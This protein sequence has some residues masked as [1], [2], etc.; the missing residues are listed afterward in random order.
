[1]PPPPL[2][3]PDRSGSLNRTVVRLALPTILMNV[4][5]PLL[6]AVDTAVVGHLRDI[7][8]LGAVGLGSLLFTMVYWTVGFFRMSTVGLAAQAHGRGDAQESAEVLGRA[9]VLALVL[10]GLAIALREIIVGAAFWYFEASP[11]VERHARTYFGIRVF[12]A[13]A[14]FVLLS[15]QGWFYGVHN[16]AFPVLVTVFVNAVNIGLDLLFVVRWGYRSDGVAWATLISQYLGLALTVGLFAWRYGD[17]WR[18][19]AP[20]RLLRWAQFRVLLALNSDIFLRTLSLQVANLYF[21]AKSAALGDAVLAANTILL[22]MRYLGT[23]GLDGFATAAEVTV[24][25]AIGAGDRP[26]LLAAIR[27][28]LGWGMAVGAL[29]SALFLAASPWWPAW[30]TSNEAVR[31]LVVAYLV[32][33]V[34]EPWVSNVPFMLDGVYIGATATRTL[35]NAMLVSVLLVFLPA[36]ELLGRAYGNHGLWAAT[37]LLYVARGATLALPLRRLWR[38]SA[39]RLR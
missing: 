14:A 8:H 28:A 9:V 7:S 35:R 12:A 26:R 10:G 19:L 33:V 21:M 37:L 20:A 36:I 5:T 1:M 30:F 38:D 32:W 4:S 2:R 34:L 23:Y 18:R 15:F 39:S 24:G 17:H 16:V 13:P 27:L 22:Q 31:G 29:I 6:G 3:A 11:E 25:A